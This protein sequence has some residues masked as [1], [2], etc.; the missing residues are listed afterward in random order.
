M[1]LGPG[2]EMLDASRTTEAMQMS[3]KLLLQVCVGGDT[4][5][6]YSSRRTPAA[7]NWNH[8]TVQQQR[9]CWRQCVGAQPSTS[10]ELNGLTHQTTLQ[11]LYFTTGF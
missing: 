11:T 8:H 4:T 5:D 3:V 1:L 9:D 2:A 10:S 6:G 7:V